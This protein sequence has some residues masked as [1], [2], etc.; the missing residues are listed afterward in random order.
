MDKEPLVFLN[1]IQKI[2]QN[3]T[4]NDL[5][6]DDVP[7]QLLRATYDSFYLMSSSPISPFPMS[8]HHIYLDL[9]QFICLAF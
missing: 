6:Y 3:K 7:S 5:R 8:K 9:F 4:T 2:Y 1:F